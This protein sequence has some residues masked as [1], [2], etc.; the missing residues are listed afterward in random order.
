MSMKWAA[1]N[2]D[3]VVKEETP[4]QLLIFF[5]FYTHPWK[6]APIW[7]L[8][9]TQPNFPHATCPLTLVMA[10]NILTKQQLGCI[11]FSAGHS[12][13][14]D[15]WAE[16]KGERPVFFTNKNTNG[17]TVAF[18]IYQMAA[19]KFSVINPR[20]I[21]HGGEPPPHVKSHW[22]ISRLGSVFS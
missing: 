2:L 5:F 7:N 20:R 4:I 21:V 19:L 18:K 13:P 8:L 15:I 17:W 6:V 10:L 22:K 3:G 14:R 11:L 9:H 1:L 16:Q 12:C